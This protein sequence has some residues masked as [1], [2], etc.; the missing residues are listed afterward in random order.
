MYYY[1]KEVTQ[2][3]VVRDL[4]KRFGRI[5]ALKG[6]TFEV[7]KGSATALLGPNGAGKTTTLK[8]LLGLLRPDSGQV[9]VFGMNPWRREDKVRSIIGVLHERP[10]YP[11][12]ASARQ[13]IRYAAK[14]RGLGEMDEGRA[15]KLSGLEDYAD[16]RVSS[17]SRGYL[18]R[19]GIALAILG[20]PE[21]LLLDEPT[22]NLDPAARMEILRLISL[23]KEELDVTVLISSHIIPELE[24]VCDSAIFIN[25]GLVLDAGSL[26]ELARRHNSRAMVTVKTKNPREL[27]SK[28]VSKGYVRSVEIIPDG[29][30]V[31]VVPGELT[32][33]E[34][35]ISRIGREYG[36]DE[37]RPA[38]G[39]LQ[40]L[41]WKVVGIAK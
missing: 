18:Q 2:V 33:L 11:E 23:L 21:L 31:E 19:L 12:W 8:I 40:D 28:L 16:V 36:I 7:K 39:K 26:D 32:A 20:D 34:N 13:L 3:I 37:I 4:W 5:Q 38:I 14:L 6:I 27:A 30:K 41:Y 35:E 10:I 9:E 24:M 15:I 22:A 29:V 17:L 1:N 25:E